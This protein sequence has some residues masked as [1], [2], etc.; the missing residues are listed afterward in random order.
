M[1][2]VDLATKKCVPCDGSTPPLKRDQVTEFLVQLKNEWEVVEDKKIKHTFQFKDFK[3]AINF[4]NEVAELAESEGHHPN[5]FI[6][7]NKVTISL[8]T[9]AVDGLSENDFILAKK[10]ENQYGALL[11]SHE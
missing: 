6:A 7:Y 2:N 10:I 9:H 5:I 8:S 11:R 1:N 3:G 4:V